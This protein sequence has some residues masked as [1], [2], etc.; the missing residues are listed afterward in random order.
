MCAFMSGDVVKRIG[1]VASGEDRSRLPGLE[2]QLR[3]LVNSAT[4]DKLF[5]LS[6]SP[7][8]YLRGEAVEAPFC[9]WDALSVTF[10]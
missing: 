5:S 6:V 3:L 7:F 9:R 1:S 4:L 10:Q 8:P 2:S